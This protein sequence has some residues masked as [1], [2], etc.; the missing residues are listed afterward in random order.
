MRTIKQT[1][2]IIRES[3]YFGAWK[4]ILLDESAIQ[5]W[6]IL[7]SAH[8]SNYSYEDL[9]KKLYKNN[10]PFVIVTEFLDELFRHLDHP[11]LDKHLTKN[12]IAQAYLG[13]KLKFDSLRIETEL[14]KKML[15]IL[16]E[17]RDL[18]NAH[19]RWMLA[20][21]DTIIGKPAEL[22]LDPTRCKVGQWLQDEDP[23]LHRIDIKKIHH[24]L[25][26]MTESAIRMYRRGDYAYFLL[27]YGDILMSSYQVRD[28]V[29]NM[30]FIKRI[31]SIYLDPL[32][33]LPNYFQVKED[34]TE[35]EGENDLLVFNISEFSKINMLYG[36]E[37]GDKI[38]KEIV[39]RLSNIHDVTQ[40]YRIY[41]DEFAI[42]FPS[43]RREEILYQFDQTI[44]Q[45]SY[46]AK[47]HEIILS[48]Y[49]SVA[50]IT[51][52][53]LEHCEY[54]LMLSKT[55]HGHIT[56]MNH[57]TEKTLQN[58]AGK[59]TLSQEL[60]LAFMDNRIIPYFQGIIDLKSGEIYK[61]EVL[62]RIRDLYGNILE[63]KAFLHHLQGMYVYPEVTKLI[64]QKSFEIFSQNDFDFSINLSFAD[65]TNPETKGFILTMLKRYPD[66]AGR[67]TFELLENEAIINPKE[68]VDFFDLL[69][70]QGVKIALDDFGAG[71]INYDTI[72][73][74]DVDY[75]KIDGVITQAMLTDHKSLVLVKSIITV[76]RELEAKIIAEFIDSEELFELVRS[77][78]ID[79]AQGFYINIPSEELSPQGGNQ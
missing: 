7:L 51:P 24:D 66:T 4:E 50:R 53:I 64:I 73:Q 67:C 22:E 55:H 33:S 48:F 77:M 11:Q 75:I 25:H 3:K 41:G 14:S 29:M 10:V 74:F 76:A 5:E 69:H 38:I 8:R 46:H 44:S 20:F 27:L 61:Y 59:I 70:S 31:A 21:I 52:H 49:G 6:E 32:T 42:L 47:G 71:Y 18:I 15:D 40:S 17:K 56:N 30:L 16:E 54:G 9:G 39:Y 19:L 65:I 57:V 13:E 36:Y 26:A 2:D 62:M 79:Y 78:D 63:P 58:Y 35:S 45:Y 23:E 68:V 72:F 1:V 43:E 60:R 34:I 37:T 28:L 12:I